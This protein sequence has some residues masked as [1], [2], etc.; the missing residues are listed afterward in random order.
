MAIYLNFMSEI[1]LRLNVVGF[2]FSDTVDL[3]PLILRELCYLQFRYVCELIALCCIVAHGNTNRRLVETYQADKIMNQMEKLNPSFY[4]YAV[5]IKKDGQKTEIT[6]QPKRDQLTKS[7]LIKLWCITG[8]VTHRSPLSKAIKPPNRDPSDFTDIREWDAK[9]IGLLD[10]HQITLA[11]NRVVLVS[12][13]GDKTGEPE[14]SILQLEP[15]SETVSMLTFSRKGAPR[16]R[17]ELP[18]RPS[19]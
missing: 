1:K 8:D 6:G 2:A 13:V 11:S 17:L 9:L 15:D 18:R 7:D 4:P 14:A 10:T 5:S 19:Q 16:R 12:L 3:P